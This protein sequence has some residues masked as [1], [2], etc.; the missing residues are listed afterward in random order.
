MST[1]ESISLLA[2]VQTPVLVGDPEGCI[3]YANPTFRDRFCQVGHDPMGEPLAMVFGGGAREAVLRATAE[4]LQRGQPARLQIREGDYGYIGLASPIEAEDDRVGVV[5]VLLEEHSN[6]E[7]VSGL[8]D[9]IAE[10]IAEATE[11][12]QT[13]TTT[14]VGRLTDDQQTLF[15]DAL[16]SM[17]S[18]GKWLR[19]LQ[20]T[21]R[22]AKSQQG[23]FDVG[24]SILRV[25]DRVLNG[26]ETKVDF[27]ILMLPN[28][29]RAVGSSVVFERLLTQL[30]HQRIDE[31]E[32]GEP[33][34]LLAR[35]FGAEPL[36]GVLVSVGVVAAGVGD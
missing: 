4:V 21:I 33:V 20:T 26:I 13:L 3:V 17:E 8:T 32:S 5:M 15:A 16:R 12:M 10:P 34:T 14:L 11:S 18:A 31:A 2:Y 36:R 9:E 24:N 25:R 19:E 30:L 23:R 6:E 28:I 27:E 35:T 29:P 22:S 7:Y 1:A